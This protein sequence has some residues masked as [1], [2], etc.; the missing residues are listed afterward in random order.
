MLTPSAA[1][2]MRERSAPWFWLAASTMRCLLARSAEHRRR[3]CCRWS[4]STLSSRLRSVSAVVCRSSHGEQATLIGDA[5]AL[6]CDE[7]VGYNST[8][9]HAVLH[10]GNDAIELVVEWGGGVG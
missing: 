3:T 7:Y 9:A 8:A 6:K 5:N 1:S 10:N 2:N 4:A